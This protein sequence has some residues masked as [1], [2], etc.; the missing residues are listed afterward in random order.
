[1][2]VTFRAFFFALSPLR[3]FTIPRDWGP[4]FYAPWCGHCKRLAPTWEKL[5]EQMDTDGIN[6]KIAKVDCTVHRDTCRHV[7]PAASLP[8]VRWNGCGG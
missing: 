2:R 8:C 6:A 3:A 1:M 4:Q 5:A 7:T